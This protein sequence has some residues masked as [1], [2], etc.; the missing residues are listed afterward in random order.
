MTIIEEE[1]YTIINNKKTEINCLET[2]N[3]SNNVNTYQL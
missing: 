2:K 1:K 3:N